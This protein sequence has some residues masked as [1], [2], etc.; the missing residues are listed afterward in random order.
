VSIMY[1]IHGSHGGRRNFDWSGKHIRGAPV[2][3]SG[4]ETKNPTT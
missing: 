2:R 4:K 1:L 3:S